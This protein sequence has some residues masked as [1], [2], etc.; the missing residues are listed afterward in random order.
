VGNLIPAVNLLVK[1]KASHGPSQ[2]EKVSVL[3]VGLNSEECLGLAE[4]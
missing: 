4:F 2:N 1:A 3:C